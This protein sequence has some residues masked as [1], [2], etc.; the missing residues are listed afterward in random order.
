MGIDKNVIRMQ[1][2]KVCTEQETIVLGTGFFINESLVLTA[3]HCTKKIEN[4]GIQYGKNNEL[5]VKGKFYKRLG[6]LA[7][8][9]LDTPVS[10]DEM[11][12]PLGYCEEL[13]E[14]TSVYIYGYPERELSGYSKE[15]TISNISSEEKRP[16]LHFYVKNMEGGLDTYELL[17]GS[18]VIYKETIIGIAMKQDKDQDEAYILS[19][20][21]F[22]KM[23]ESL[24]EE[25]IPL[26]QV[27]I[28]QRRSLNTGALN[29]KAWW[30]MKAE[31]KR[32][33]T[34]SDRYSII[35]ATLLL[36]IQ[37]RGDIILASSW[38]HG[39][40]DWLEKETCYYRK[41]I[42]GWKGRKWYN[43]E[44]DNSDWRNLENNS[45]VV[46]YIKAEEYM[47]L[48]ESGIMEG[49][50]VV[51]GNILV[52]WNIWSE[53]PEVAIDQAVT[54]GEQCFYRNEV[55]VLTIFSS[56]KN[57]N[58]PFRVR[59]NANRWVNEG[60]WKEHEADSFLAKLDQ[61]EVDVLAECFLRN[62]SRISDEKNGWDTIYIRCSESVLALS[63]LNGLEQ[64][65]DWLK[66]QESI[67]S[68][69]VK[70][71]FSEIKEEDCRRIL[72]FL[73]KEEN[74]V[75]YWVIIISNPYCVRYVLKE[76]CSLQEKKLVE[77]IL[78]RNKEDYSDYQ[79]YEIAENI[80][81]KI[82]P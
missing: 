27:R 62:F 80:R 82:R 26:N 73:K 60:K 74:E 30:L 14:G 46:I 41:M 79:Q 16:T 67:D 7:F 6:M 58:H 75:L 35:L 76:S 19:A 13:S 48:M 23:K 4:F 56:W 21:D 28:Q 65:E 53:N 32:E 59:G 12:L 47:Q 18:P 61:E 34:I 71:W 70:R 42:P 39:I 81:Y 77:L 72:D 29:K 8:I 69:A 9:K 63:G 25:K 3:A 5:T 44:R 66:K 50:K 11:L 54:M 2:V 33:T 40:E 52:I 1:T 45:G 57:N 22:S 43:F 15:F 38:K 68:A 37:E 31:R 24:Q 49:R 20:I 17:S 36:G 78:N 51:N 10:L 64:L 55:D